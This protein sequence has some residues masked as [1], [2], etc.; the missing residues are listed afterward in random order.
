MLHSL[1]VV[2]V[3]ELPART[4]LVPTLLLPDLLEALEFTRLEYGISHDE[5]VRVSSDMFEAMDAWVENK[6]PD[7]NP[8]TREE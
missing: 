6:S 4:V 5:T 1:L 7:G 8:L 2:E 3:P